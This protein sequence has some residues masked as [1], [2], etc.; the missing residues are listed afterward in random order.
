MRIT[1]YTFLYNEE[2]ILPYF[3]KH[4]STMVDKIVVYDNKSTDNSIQILKDWKDCE[5]ELREYDTNDQLDELSLLDLKNNC[6]KDDKSDYIIVCDVDELLY[7][8]NF[9]EFIKKNSMVDYFTPSGYHMIG[10]EIPTDYTKQIYDIIQYGTEDVNYG[11]NILFK[12]SN[13]LETY[14]APGAHL[15]SF[16]GTGRLIN[17]TTDQL[18]LLHYKWLSP[19]YVIKKYLHYQERRSE[20]SKEMGWGIHYELT[21]DQIVEKYNELKN[22]SFLII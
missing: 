17:C 9:K 22:N 19:D 21:P 7:H 18:K 4:Y 16:K 20:H 5:I 11:K 15:S 3:L 1:L 2:E 12:R 8:T 13:V 10:D 6:W 14:Y